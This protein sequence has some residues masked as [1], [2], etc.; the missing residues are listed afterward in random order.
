[1][2][3][4]LAVVLVAVLLHASWASSARAADLVFD[5][6]PGAILANVKADAFSVT[7][8]EGGEKVS[9]MSS[10]PMVGIGVSIPQPEGYIIDLKAGG[11]L[12]LN[13]AL[14]SFMVYGMAGLYLEMRPGL[15]FGPHAAI[16]SFTAPDWWGKN[17]ITFSSDTGFLAGV[18]LAAGDRI[19]YLLSVDYVSTAFDVASQ[20]DNVIASDSTLDMS[21]I[22]VQFGIRAQF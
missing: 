13:G 9:L 6:L 10:L 20:G 14:S 16:T 11:G 7:G 1:M 4:F 19:A 2:R 5:V 15:L 3:R 17:D 21:G 8:P 12:L 22:A 18:H